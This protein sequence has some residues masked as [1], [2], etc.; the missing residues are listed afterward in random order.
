MG[1]QNKRM[2]RKLL[3][4][5]RGQSEPRQCKQLTFGL[6]MKKRTKRLKVNINVAKKLGEQKQSKYMNTH[7]PTLIFLT[8]RLKN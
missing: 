7:Q 4:R 2:S 3:S 5:K 6:N 8:K 1:L